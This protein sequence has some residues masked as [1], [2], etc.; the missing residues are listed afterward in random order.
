MMGSY[1]SSASFD[2]AYMKPHDFLKVST[3]KHGRKT[4]FCFAQQRRNSESNLV[5][6]FKFCMRFGTVVVVFVVL[7]SIVNGMPHAK[8]WQARHCGCILAESY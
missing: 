4:C 7:A 3:L 2:E 6:T 1:G 5:Y 8:Y